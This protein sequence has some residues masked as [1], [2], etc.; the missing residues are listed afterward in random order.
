M[1]N[2][3]STSDSLEYER[4]LKKLAAKSGPERLD[5]PLTAVK[6]MRLQQLATTSSVP[7]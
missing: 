2:N 5:D 3:T 7:H 1:P 6:D 4:S